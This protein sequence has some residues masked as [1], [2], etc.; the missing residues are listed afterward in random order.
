MTATTKTKS[1]TD[2]AIDKLL[3]FLTFKVS[4]QNTI[5]LYDFFKSEGRQAL[6]DEISFNPTQT[7]SHGVYDLFLTY[8]VSFDYKNYNDDPFYTDLKDI[9]LSLGAKGATAE[10]NPDL[11]C[12]MMGI[13]EGFLRRIIRNEYS[14]EDVFK[15]AYLVCSALR[16]ISYSY[17]KEFLKKG[18]QSYTIHA[19][20]IAPGIGG[21]ECF[22]STLYELGNEL[23]TY[24]KLNALFIPVLEN[25]YACTSNKNISSPA[26]KVIK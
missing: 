22:Y 10:S 2:E 5:C 12:E 19:I 9:I 17:V 4:A 25:I 8:K 14:K 24:E 23:D 15:H 18:L 21:R 7:Y 11:I 13:S 3:G 1:V 20:A 16:C 26:L 6:L